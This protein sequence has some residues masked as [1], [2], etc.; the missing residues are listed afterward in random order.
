VKILNKILHFFGF[1]RRPFISSSP[2]FVV[3]DGVKTIHVYG[4]GG[5][6]G[7]SGKEID[8]VTKTK[9]EEK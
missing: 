1:R 8:S 7:G 5:G 3:P 4:A 9:E 2:V 6:G